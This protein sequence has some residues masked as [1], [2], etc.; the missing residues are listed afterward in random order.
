[1]PRNTLPVV[2]AIPNYNMAPDLAELLPKLQRQNYADI[3]VLDDASTDGS[4]EVVEGCD[5]TITFISSEQNQ[6]AGATRNKIIPALGYRALIHFIDADT[7]PESQENPEIIQDILGA[8]IGF[9]G[10]FIREPNGLQNPFNYGPAH[11]LGKVATGTLQLHFAALLDKDREK[12]QAFHERYAKYLTNWPNPL[13]PPESRPVFWSAEAN[14]AIDSELFTAVEG[15]DPRL[16]QEEIQDLAMKLSRRG[17]ARR[18]HPELTIAHKATQVR[19]GN[20][21]LQ[22]FKAEM[23]LIRKYGARNWLKPELARQ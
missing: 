15:F 6:G 1:M 4:R 17:L 23:Q 12:A 10:G 9:A 14:F 20:L 21:A 18:F 3:F 8:E 11:S 22:I 13:A 7:L 5:S 2:A 19:T 16:R